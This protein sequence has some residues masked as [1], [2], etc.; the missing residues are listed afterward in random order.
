MHADNSGLR[1]HAHHKVH[2]KCNDTDD[3]TMAVCNLGHGL[4]ILWL[5]GYDDL[6]VVL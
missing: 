2:L 5:W 4:N 6:L 3:D 1:A